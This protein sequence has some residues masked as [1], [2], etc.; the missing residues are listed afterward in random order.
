MSFLTG[1]ISGHYTLE[2]LM[3]QFKVTS[4]FPYGRDITITSL[5]DDTAAASPGCLYLGHG[6]GDIPAEIRNAQA[7]GAYCILF[8]SSVSKVI[9]QK[10][11]QSAATVPVLFGDLNQFDLGRLAYMLA[12][13]PTDTL[14]TFGVVGSQA[15]YASDSLAQLLHLLGNPIGVIDSRRSFSLERE[16][17]CTYPLNPID[18]EMIL[19]QMLEDGANTVVLTI[20]DRTFK[21]GALSQVGLDVCG[22]TQSR[23]M[24]DPLPDTDR[25]GESGEAAQDDGTAELEAE[26]IQGGNTDAGIAAGPSSD[27]TGA[28]AAQGAGAGIPQPSK[29]TWSRWIPSYHR[30]GDN[31][32][33]G[34]LKPQL[35]RSVKDFGAIIND[36]THCVAPTDAAR[37]VVQ[38]IVETADIRHEYELYLAAAM[39]MSAGVRKNNVRSALLLAQEI[40]R[41]QEGNS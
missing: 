1:N 39:A 4:T 17:T 29:R 6:D 41:R 24:A 12:G 22:R 2:D 9:S 18:T 32:E 31:P 34:A 19:S 35:R 40:N 27:G 25:V 36:D 16:L 28:A 8:P 30:S 38:S 33:I 26:D 21:R 7:Q 15:T 37:Q 3:H 20:N 23:T 5:T 13:Q 14:A 11:L 10:E